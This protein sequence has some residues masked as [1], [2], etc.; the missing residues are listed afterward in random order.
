MNRFYFIIP[1]LALWGI[2]GGCASTMA[3]LDGSTAEEL[4]KFSMSRDQLWDERK[5]LKTENKKLQSRANLLQRERGKSKELEKQIGML[6]ERIGNE[7]NKIR[8]FES[9]IS[10]IE[11]EKDE[12]EKKISAL[13]QEKIMLERRVP[14]LEREK[15]VGEIKIKVLSG[16][17]D[18]RSATQMAARLK[19]LGYKIKLIDL[20]PRK[21]Y[22]RHTVFFKPTS[23]KEANRLI[24][25]LGGRT[26]SKPL[27]WPS[28]FDLIV[29]AVRNP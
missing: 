5:R 10:M 3:K 8:E 6:K 21:T 1:V 16:N 22:K 9:K 18:I 17:G 29:V 27:S 13:E 28:V 4:E 23:E 2:L 15:E 20:A 14:R 19:K 12:F 24:N 25:R 11:A 7:R 26:I